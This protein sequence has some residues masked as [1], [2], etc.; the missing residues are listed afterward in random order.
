MSSPSEKECYK[1]IQMVVLKLQP[2]CV[3]CGQPSIVG[4]HW[5]KRDRLATAFLPEAISGL[6]NVCHL[7][8]HA[9]PRWFR[10]YMINRFGENNYYSLLAL[11]CT[12]VPDFDFEATKNNLKKLLDN[13]QR[14]A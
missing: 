14:Q 8:A 2:V 11:S 7:F 4:H 13:S 5:F 6:C 9:R 3:M 10:E 1:L 12:V